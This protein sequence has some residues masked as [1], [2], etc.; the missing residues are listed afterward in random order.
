MP[1]S[2]AHQCPQLRIVR[3]AGAALLSFPLLA[4]PTVTDV[5]LS[6]EPGTSD[7]LIDYGLGDEAAIVTVDIQRKSDGNWVSIGV[8]NLT[9]LTGDVHRELAAS[10]SYTV[11]WNPTLAWKDAPSEPVE[12]RAVVKA[13]PL[14]NP[15]DVLVAQLMGR[16]EHEY[17]D[18]LCQLPGGILGNE[19]Y[20]RESIVM[21]RCH[22][23]GRTFTLGRD[24]NPG[25]WA[26]NW[27]QRDVTFK[28][29]FYI[30]VFEL[31]GAQMSS[32]RRWHP[33]TKVSGAYDDNWQ[34][35]P[36]NGQSCQWMRGAKY[37]DPPA[38]DSGLDNFYT[39]TGIRFDLPSAAQW[40][41]AARA[42]LSAEYLGR[43]D[44][45]APKFASYDAEDSDG[46]VARVAT[47]NASRAPD[48][49]ATEVGSH[50]PNAFGLYDVFGNV[51]EFCLDRISNDL[52]ADQPADETPM[53]NPAHTPDASGRGHMAMGGHYDNPPSKCSISSNWNYWDTP[54]DTYCFRL[55][56]PLSCG[57][58]VGVV[59]QPSEGLVITVER[60]S[61]DESDEKSPL[62]LLYRDS[63][64][65][66]GASLSGEPAGLI[67]IVQ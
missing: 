16:L 36:F 39:R 11:R 66:E 18:D 9:H 65:S 17:Y 58:A 30:G 61:D 23:A 10:G 57:T 64:E 27:A 19:Q 43:E 67:M 45:P 48:N 29:D 7:L 49:R 60:P 31:T 56:A 14:D 55:V 53:M 46:T 3:A 12:V 32:A 54:Y 21:R 28:N 33:D 63:E 20:K 4:A 13:Y 44:I 6:Q 42:G 62:A 1:S 26:P 15:P 52:A 40:E 34:K 51:A 2:K 47:F 22:A 59:S 41:F 25:N 38:A 5:V 35:R 37:P 50:E 8:T 24:Y